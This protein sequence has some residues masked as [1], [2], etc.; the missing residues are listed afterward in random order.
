MKNVVL[1]PQ[2]CGNTMSV[3]RK[4]SVF[5][6]ESLANSQKYLFDIV[7][8][9]TGAASC[10]NIRGPKGLIADSATALPDAVVQDIREAIVL[11]GVQLHESSV[12]TG[13]ISFAGDTSKTVA[14]AGGLLNN[15]EYRVYYETPDGTQLRTADGQTTTS[16]TAVAPA[17]YGTVGVPV[18]V[19]YVVYV[20]TLDSSV[21]GGV[22]T[23]TSADTAGKTVTLP[24]T[25]ANTD[26]RVLTTV[27]DFIPV[28]VTSKTKTSFK[29][30][31]GVSLESP[32]TVIVGY[33]V[34]V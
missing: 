1:K 15:A 28:K 21:T 2:G 22:L 11:S 16:F 17:E 26:Y 18:V 20:S 9:S 6:Y 24:L 4:Q 25:M 14:I 34:V 30:I 13:T 23:F 33:D 19:D 31:L 5:T 12:V 27:A 3:T 32:N 7:L 10:R 8:D 29:I